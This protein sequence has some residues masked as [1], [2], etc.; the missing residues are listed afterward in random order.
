MKEIPLTQGKVA[1]V[2]DEDYD[3]LMQWKWQATKTKCTWYAKRVSNNK[4]KHK[5]GKR[6]SILM[7]R[8]IMKAKLFYEV[9]HNPDHNGLNNQKHNLRIAT[10][11][12]NKINTHKIN[13][14]GYR[15]VE[16]NKYS[17]KF[18]AHIRI[19]GKLKH[20]GV[21][22]TAIEAAKAYNNAAVQYHDKFAILNIFK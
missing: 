8:V 17:K 20:L 22:E 12:Q 1:L 7:H 11:T 10:R 14:T 4:D 18:S 3:F 21:F 9:D 19:N 16:L 6:Y 13:S 2:D 5:N 15:G